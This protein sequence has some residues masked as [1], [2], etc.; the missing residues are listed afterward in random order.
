MSLPGCTS[1]GTL[2]R[3]LGALLAGL[4]ILASPELATWSLVVLNTRTGEVCVASATCL[5]NKF[6]LK[7]WLPVIV[8]A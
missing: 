5:G 2:R 3:R 6:P 1:R 4:L 8:V 7:L